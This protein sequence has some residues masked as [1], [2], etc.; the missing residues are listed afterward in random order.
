[1]AT[2]THICN[3]ALAHLGIGKKISTFE[4]DRSEQ[5]NACRSFYD[6]ARLATL[7]DF[8]WPF[9]TKFIALG[10]VAINPT[11]EWKY[12]YAYPSDC[13]HFRRILSGRRNDTYQS[14]IP[15]RFVYGERSQEIY[16][17]QMN[18]CA[19]YGVDVTDT[20]RFPHDFVMAFSFRLAA[21]LAPGLTAGDP[22][23]LGDAA[24]K[25]YLYE[26]SKAKATAVNEEQKDKD[27]ESEFISGRN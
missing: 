25:N 27:P 15:Y 22:Y 5:G 14:R 21:Y 11:T 4:T 1:M 17:D 6:S 23:K 18:A 24:T 7:R 10:L 9:N 2:P 16:T 3:L 13:L 19:E 12:S 8:E 26:I 20:S